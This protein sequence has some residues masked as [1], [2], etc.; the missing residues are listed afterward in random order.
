MEP[1]ANA[2]D[3]WS[4]VTMFIEKD[5]EEMKK[6]ASEFLK[7]CGKTKTTLINELISYHIS[8]SAKNFV[9]RYDINKR[10]LEKAHS[11]RGSPQS[12]RHKIDFNWVRAFKAKAS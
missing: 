8:A 6:W 5:D 7:K 2:E 10:F 12:D 1:S 3:K 11:F 4:R 9:M